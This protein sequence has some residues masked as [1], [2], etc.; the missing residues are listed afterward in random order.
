MGLDICLIN[1]A[2]TVTGTACVMYIQENVHVMMVSMVTIVPRIVDVK[3][4]GS[5]NQVNMV[6]KCDVL[7]VT[8]LN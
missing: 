3:A 6:K 5:A 4:M 7:R 2:P 1:S 8:I